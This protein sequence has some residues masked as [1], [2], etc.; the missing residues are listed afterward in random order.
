MNSTKADRDRIKELNG[1]YVGLLDSDEI[2]SLDRC[3]SDHVAIKDYNH[4]G[5]FLELAKVKIISH[6]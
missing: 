4:V 1:L 6:D 2:E 3:I 5:G